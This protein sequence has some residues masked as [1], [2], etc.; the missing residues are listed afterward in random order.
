MSDTRLYPARPIVG[1]GAVIVDEEQVVLVR[2]R[3]EPL[4]GRWSLPGGSL[5]VGETLEAGVARE[6]LEET[7]LIVRVGPVVEVFDRIMYDDDG[8]VRYHFVLVD[9]LCWPVAGTLQAGSD[10]DAVA[11]TQ[12]GQLHRFDLTDKATSVITRAFALHT[13]L[14][15]DG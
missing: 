4:A 15:H 6:M 13:T 12:P 11:L 9:Y 5:E 8:R 14:R 2:R 10:A 7:G 3:H 1:V